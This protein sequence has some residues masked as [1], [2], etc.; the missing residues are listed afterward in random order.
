MPARLAIKFPNETCWTEWRRFKSAPKTCGAKALD[1]L[2][3]LIDDIK[4]AKTENEDADLTEALDFQRKASF[5]VD[6]VVSDN[7][8]GFHAPQEAARILGTSIDFS[9]KGQNA[10]RN[11]LK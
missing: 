7:S 11:A 9:R 2:V 5:Y 10:V 3:D 6:F 1:A 4:A 8:N